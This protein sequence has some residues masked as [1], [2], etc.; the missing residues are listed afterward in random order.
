MHYQ[1]VA[2]VERANV[3]IDRLH[4]LEVSCDC[5]E[6]AAVNDVRILLFLLMRLRSKLPGISGSMPG[7]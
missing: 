5:M 7:S 3:I 1:R 2:F 6:G 4:A